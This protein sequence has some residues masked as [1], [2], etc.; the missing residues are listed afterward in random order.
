MSI[1]DILLHIDDSPACEQRIDAALV[2][3]QTHA[4]SLTG[5]SIMTHNY[6]QPEHQNDEETSEALKALLETKALETGVAAAWRGIESTVVGVGLSEVLINLSH[7]SD[8]VVVGQET[9]RSGRNAALVERLVLG[10]GRPILVIPVIGTFPTIGKRV[11]LAWKRG[12][13]AARAAHDAFPFLKL[14]DQVT[15]LSVASDEE[16]AQEPWDGI[17]EHLRRH[18]IQA[19]TEVQPATSAPPADGLLNLACEGGY[20]LLVM[21]AFCAA[22]GSGAQLGPVASQILREMTVPVLLSH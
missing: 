17:L 22:S 2:V 5:L 6:Y 3:A 20:D 19:R 11:L 21:G 12:R 18:G 8:L 10:A 9:G 14:A 13:E 1:K 4:A 15:L 7:C 16:V